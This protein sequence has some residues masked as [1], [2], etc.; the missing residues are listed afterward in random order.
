M[1]LI[2]PAY[3]KLNLTLDVLGRRADG[4]HEIATVLQTISLHDVLEV[5]RSSSTVFEASGLPV[6]GENLVEK[7]ARQ[8]EA[9]IGRPLPFTI[10]LHKRI[11]IGAGLG[12]G[13]ADAAAFLR[14]AV[15]LASLQI[16]TAELDALAAA[17]GQ[18]VPF[19]LRG[20]TAVATGL[21]STVQRLPP[22]PA[23][24]AFLVASPPIE[25]KTSTVYAAVDGSFQS[26]GR[27]P[28][29]AALLEAEGTPDPENF[30][31][32]LEPAALRLYPELERLI[33]PLR[34]GMERLRM[35]G[36]GGCFFASFESVE[37][38]EVALAEVRDCGVPL[39]ICR[40]VRSWA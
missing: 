30:G 20:G 29:V 36:T 18:D 11:P 23:S 37:A 33:A 1:A 26:A 5:E 31:N 7:A 22:L 24:W 6:K 34:S 14:A 39:S 8:L 38:A 13:S 2:V 4:Y 40:P 35:T 9:H 10:R 21:G 28:S 15:R 25:V 27:T 32:D 3:A 16:P 19:L 12:G 17:V